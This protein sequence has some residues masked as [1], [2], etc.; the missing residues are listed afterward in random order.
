MYTYK[1]CSHCHRAIPEH[2]GRCIPCEEQ[3]EGGNV[4]TYEVHGFKG[5]T[6]QKRD[7]PSLISLRAYEADLGGD[8]ELGHQI[9]ALRVWLDGVL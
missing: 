8:V 2:D 3:S 5:Q 9:R 6:I 4:G 1:A 7:V